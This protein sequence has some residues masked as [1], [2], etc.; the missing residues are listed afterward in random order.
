MVGAECLLAD[1]QRSLVERV[2][3]GVAALVLVE[4]SQIVQRLRD[5][6]MARTERLLADSQRSL[7]ERLGV[8]I[9]A[10][11]P[12]E[13]SQIV[14]RDAATS[15]WSGPSAFSRIASDRFKS[16]SASA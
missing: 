1:R 9:V 12:I 7:E 5:I 10:L 11:F 15:G 16:G 3:V 13:L 6:G 8:G 14:Q 4:Q 2:G